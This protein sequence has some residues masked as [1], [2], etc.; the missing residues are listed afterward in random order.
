MGFFTAGA[1]DPYKACISKVDYSKCVEAVIIQ[2][3]Q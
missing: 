1:H 2:V 3:L